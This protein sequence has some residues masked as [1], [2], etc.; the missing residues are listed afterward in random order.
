MLKTV[1]KGENM[2]NCKTC[3]KEIENGNLIGCPRCG[4]TFCVDCARS[5]MRICPKCYTDLEYMG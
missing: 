3:N 5:S 2:N 1:N 4:A